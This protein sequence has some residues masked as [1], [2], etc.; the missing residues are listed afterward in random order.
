MFTK[1]ITES[2]AFLDMPMSTQCL[3]FHLNMAADDD[4][5]VNSPK[6]IQRLVGANDDDMKLL[7]AK[8]FI[9]RFESGIIVIK[10]WKMHNYIQSDRYKPTDYID[11]K[12]MLTLKKNKAY[13]LNESTLDTKCIQDVSVGKDRL[14]KDRLGKSYIYSSH[15]E[16]VY[17]VYPRKGDKKRAYE[18]YKAR[19]NDG[20]SEEELLTATKN[21]AD[22]CK[23]E[24]REQKY[25]K[26]APTFYGVNTPF[27]DYLP[28]EP[29]N[30]EPEHKIFDL[31]EQYIAP[32]FGFPEAWFDGDRLIPDRVTPILRP[33]DTSMGYYEDKTIMPDELIRDYEA[34]RAWHEENN[35]RS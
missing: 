19:L 32:Y 30:K 34:R 7:I 25:I 21:Y 18:C 15:F 9:I 5:F 23:K 12:N 4:G 29:I 33:K 13:T 1:K 8:S 11:E 24:N 2:D 6:R 27:V 16:E 3:Y 10:H 22:Y 26:V 17:S 14:G 20:F 28:K 31:D 35:N